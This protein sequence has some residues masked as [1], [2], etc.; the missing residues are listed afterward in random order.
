MGLLSLCR[1]RRRHVG[2]TQQVTMLVSRCSQM[3]RLLPFVQT[4]T[5]GSLRPAAT[6]RVAACRTL[7]AAQVG[8]WMI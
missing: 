4:T 3:A 7:L 8:V 6:I 2:L 1:P 5:S